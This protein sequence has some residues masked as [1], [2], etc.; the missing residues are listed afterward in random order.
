MGKLNCLS[1][2]LINALSKDIANFRLSAEGRRAVFQS[3]FLLTGHA[4]SQDLL[5]AGGLP[6]EGTA[7]GNGSPAPPNTALSPKSYPLTCLTTLKQVRG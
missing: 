6:V 7:E 2:S 5:L 4:C 1:L 3:G